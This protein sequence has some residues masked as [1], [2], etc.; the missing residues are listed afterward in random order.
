MILKFLF[1]ALIQYEV[2]MYLKT[3]VTY[4]ERHTA[5]LVTMLE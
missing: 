1:G 4:F 2:Y 3:I 5:L